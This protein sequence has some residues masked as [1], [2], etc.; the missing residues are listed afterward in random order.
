[1]NEDQAIL[2]KTYPIGDTGLIVVWIT[3]NYGLIRT[4]ARGVL[5]PNNAFSGKLDLFFNDIIQW[6]FSKKSNLHSLVSASVVYPR[7]TIRQEYARLSLASY[8]VRL[9]LLITE[10]DTPVPEFYDLLVRALNYLDTTS[11]TQ[12]A[13]FHFERE[14]V[15]LHGLHGS[16][17]SPCDILSRH[18]GKI[19]THQRNAILALLAN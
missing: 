4:A 16:R 2:L 1:M 13:L 6:R 17:E 10:P 5:R 14:I 9:L 12:K 19:P 3:K 15:R 8:F 7:L 18:F 11:P